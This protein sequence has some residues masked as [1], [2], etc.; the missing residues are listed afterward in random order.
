M[1][2]SALSRRIR[3]DKLGVDP[4]LEAITLYLH[5]IPITLRNFE[6][7]A[8]GRG[9]NN[10]SSRR[11]CRPDVYAG[12]LHKSNLLV[13]RRR[14]SARH[15]VS[16]RC[17]RGNL[18][19]GLGRHGRERSATVPEFRLLTLRRRWRPKSA[20]MHNAAQTAMMR[21]C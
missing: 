12:T 5:P 8:F 11:G 20:V 13:L 14:H 16:S 4:T 18:G 10:S 17:G 15:G 3:P 21:S 6:A 2:Q 9:P 1:T 19:S 7:C